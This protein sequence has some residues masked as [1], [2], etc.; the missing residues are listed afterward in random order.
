MSKE[1]NQE[2]KSDNEITEIHCMVKPDFRI[3]GAH[4][5]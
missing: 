3:T 5:S 4:I 2:N 1:G